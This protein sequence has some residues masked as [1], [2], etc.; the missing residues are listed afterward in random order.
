MDNEKLYKINE[1][2]DKIDIMERIAANWD[3]RLVVD[4]PVKGVFPDLE[5]KITL[6]IDQ[7]LARLE[8]EFKDM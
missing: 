4:I 1:A 7:E 3:D 2:K 8:N 6:V 5:E